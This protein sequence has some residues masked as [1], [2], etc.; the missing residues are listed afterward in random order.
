MLIIGSLALR[1]PLVMAPM[2]GVTDLPF[3]LIVREQG[4]H[5]AC[6]EMISAVG[7]TRGSRR[8]YEYLE[9]SE[10]DHPLQVQI[11]GADPC[12]MAKAA[13]I[14][15]DMG[16]DLI[17]INMGCPVKKVARTGAGAALLNNLPLI[18]YILSS[19]RKAT[20]LPLTVKMRS[21]WK[22]DRICAVEVAHI[23]EE[24]GVDAVI[25]HPRTADQGYQ[26]KADWTVI[27]RVKAAVKIPVIGNG[28]IRTAPDGVL[29][30]TNTGCDAVM[31]GRG[32][33][34]Y[35]WIFREIDALFEGRHL[36]LPPTWEER[37]A[38]ID[39]HL[40]LV[41]TRWGERQGIRIFRK[42]LLWYTWGLRGGA[43]LRRQL[44][45]VTRPEEITQ[46]LTG[47]SLCSPEIR[48]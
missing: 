18:P 27:A 32:A 36:P 24:E 20:S 40:R 42:H 13:A 45:R 10:R 21:G 25:V 35:P 5:L 3:R 43:G 30:R 22:R 44:C 4:C 11:F 17:D 1:G 31:I 14:A 12:T 47:T 9:T 16:A 15:S 19:V 8:S 6:T 7:L 46:L 41:V 29:M 39:R 48:T 28:D 37:Y 34:G 38:T 23:A 33:L 2:A 26:G